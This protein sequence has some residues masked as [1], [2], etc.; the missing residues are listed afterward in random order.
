[1]RSL[2]IVLQRL[3]IKNRSLSEAHRVKGVLRV[4]SVTYTGKVGETVK[5]HEFDVSVASGSNGAVDMSVQFEEYFK[6]L[7]DQVRL[8]S[9]HHKH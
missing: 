3:N 7:V 5:K 4:D 2:L 9:T 1:M 8:F 6:K